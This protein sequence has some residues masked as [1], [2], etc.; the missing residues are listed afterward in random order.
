MPVRLYKIASFQDETLKDSIIDKNIISILYT[1]DGFSFA[2]YDSLKNKFTALESFRIS[3]LNKNIF[4]ES[5]HQHFQAALQVELENSVLMT[6]HAAK[7]IVNVATNQSTWVPLSLFDEQQV[8]N[9]L[10]LNFQEPEGVIRYEINNA[11]DAVCAYSVYESVID[12]FETMF[13]K[14]EIHPLQN[15]LTTQFYAIDKKRFE[16]TTAY[17]FVEASN[18]QL[19]VFKDKKLIFSNRFC[20]QSSRDFAFY[21]LSVYEK[22]NLSPDTVPLVFSGDIFNDAEIWQLLWKYIRNMHYLNGNKHFDFSYHFD[23]LPIHQ[24]FHL[25]NAI[26]CV[27]LEEN[28]KVGD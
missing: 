10:R 15:T 2:L 25:F 6:M 26:S 3:V 12:F 11:I 1:Q 21:L 7:A 20:Y 13:P 23:H 4:N 19:F 14:S 22:L 5:F 17:C 24:Y 28:G 18:F 16:E 9:Y 8:E 27:L